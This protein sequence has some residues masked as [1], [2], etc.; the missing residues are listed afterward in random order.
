MKPEQPAIEFRSDNA[1]RVAPQLIEAL[2]QA[3]E[4]TALGYG[5]DALT[6][7]LQTRFAELFETAVR[8]FPV[9]TGTAANALSLASVC[10]PFGAVYCS[11][12]A[13]INTSESNATGFFSGG[14]K[15]VPL[16]GQHG[17]VSAQALAAAIAGAGVGLAHKSQPAAVNLVQATD[18]GAVYSL[19][20]I[21]AI[22]EVAHAHGLKVHMDGARFANAVA[23]LG[24]S[25]A[26]AAWKAGVDIL[27]FGVTKNGGLLG[28]AIVV[29]APD[30]PPALGQH[31]R[32]A[33][34]VWSKMRFAS[35]QILAYLE[36]DLWLKLARGANQAAASIAA[37]VGTLPGV[38]LV[39]PVEANELFIETDATVLDALQADGIL[40]YRRGPRLGRFVCRWD[41]S[42]AEVDALATAIA[43]HVAR[44]A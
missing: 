28:D 15:M 44:R 6:A 36:G 19:D 7:R 18:L 16:P 34:M 26:Q 31:L 35:A 29:F 4:G 1:G 9:P 13:H 40:F 22:A 41:T 5:A 30:A 24:C 38:R 21:A 11:P 39:A 37:L 3:N 32:R 33:G 25:P 10:T 27:S 8:V 14:A 42:A 2:V 12:D 17:K 43:R 23:S 20:E